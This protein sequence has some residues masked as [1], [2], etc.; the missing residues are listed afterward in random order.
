MTGSIV[1]QNVDKCRGGDF[2]GGPVVK[3]QP[4]NGEDTGSIPG[5]GAKIPHAAEQPSPCATNTEPVHR[6]E[7]F[8]QDET[9]IPMQPNK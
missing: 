3:N 8:P 5:Q 4:C 7:R 2:P 9:K 1:G 6:K